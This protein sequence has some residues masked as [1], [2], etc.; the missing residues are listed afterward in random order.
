MKT[1]QDIL[2]CVHALCTQIMQEMGSIHQFDR[3]LAQTLLAESA[4]VQLI[5][6]EDLAKSLIVLHTDLEASSEVLLSDIMK[7]LD[8]PPNDPASHQVKSILQRFQ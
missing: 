2:T 3:T 1:T 8:L 7:T 5:I 6:S 4:R